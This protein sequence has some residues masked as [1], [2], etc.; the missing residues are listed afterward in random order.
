MILESKPWLVSIEPGTCFWH[1]KSAWKSMKAFGGRE[2]Y[3]IDQLLPGGA[4]RLAAGQATLM[5]KEL[6]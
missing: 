3:P 2:M 4:H 6:C 5:G 1:T